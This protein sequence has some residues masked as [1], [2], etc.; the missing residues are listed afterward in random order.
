MGPKRRS[1][2]TYKPNRKMPN[3]VRKKPET[4]FSVDLLA[5]ALNAVDAGMSFRDAAKAFG[6]PKSTLCHKF[7]RKTPLDAKKGPRTVLTQLEEKKI[8]DYLIYCGIRGF[9]ITKSQ[10]LDCVAKFIQETGR[11]T[12]FKDGRPGK[13]W[14]EAFLRRNPEISLRISQNLTLTRASVTQE[15]LHKWFDN[16]EAHFVR[17]GL[18]TI[19]P[20]RI[21]NCDESAFML[22]PKGES[23]LVKRGS[24]N[25]YQIVGGNEK[26]TIT[27]L[28]MFSASGTMPPPMVLFEGKNTLRKSVLEK[29]PSGWSV[30]VTENG[31]MT[32]ES[33]FEYVT[34]VF[35]KWLK[36][37]NVEFPIILYID[38]HVSHITLPL[39]NFCRDHQIELTALYPNAT[40]LIQPL[41][42][43]LF[44]VLE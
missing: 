31:W 38:G 44:R 42:V 36:E 20:H 18:N 3:T 34:N 37:N 13:Y 15:S 9:P 28:F 43:S 2:S 12:P 39:C 33:F 30:G 5:K 26:D 40:H 16:V 25:V 4:K 17:E 41:D 14:F 8:L 24:R 21:F 7:H 27:V 10:L 1:V 29:I 11:Q 22:N 23:V 6:V 19:G 35:Y 32:A